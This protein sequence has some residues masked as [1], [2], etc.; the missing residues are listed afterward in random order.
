MDDPRRRVPR[1]D[2]LLADPR[3]AEAERVLGRA[4]VKSVV[5]E[6]QQRARAGEIE[7]E[8]VADARRRRTAASARRACGPSSTPPASSCTPTWAARRCRRPRWTRWSP[9]AAPPTSSSTW[10]PAA[11]PA[12]VAVRW[13][14]WPARCPTAGGVHVVNNN[15][16]ALL[17]TAM[18]LAP[19]KEI[20]VS[21]G[22]LIEIGDGFR[23]PELMAVDRFADPRG[24]HHQ[25]HPPA[26][27]RRRDRAGHRLRAQGAPV[28]LPRHAASPRRCRSPSW[29]QLD[30]P[31]VV[32]IGSGLLTP[33]PLLPDEPDATTVL[34]DGADLVTASGDKLLGGPQAGLL[35][36]D[37]ELIERLRRHPAAR[38]LRVDKLTLAALEATLVGPPPPVAQALDAD[39]TELRARAEA[40]RRAAARGAGGGLHRGRRRRR[41]TRRRA[42]ERRRQ[43]ARVLRR[44][45]AHRHAGGRRAARGRPLPARP[46]HGRAGGRRGC[47]SRRCGHV[48]RSHRRSRRP[49][50]VDARAAAHRHVARPAGRGAAPRPDHRPRLRVDR[51]RRTAV[52]VRRR[53]G[54]RAVRREHARRRRPGARGDVRRRRDRGLD[55]AVRRAP[56][57]AATR[58]ASGTCWS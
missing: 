53:A 18:T 4:L 12:A 54:P 25:P 35:F 31:L 47:W 57:R 15:A 9:P 42:A 44:T 19:G 39:V 1:T 3:L 20:V 56:R 38:A 34:R 22:E 2:V 27:L 30:V 28:E 16:A 14:R 46:A 50:Q 5:A 36:G 26:R 45:A 48:R 13:P 11:A 43:P 33:H 37:A 17:L 40:A 21:R 8:Q 7:P 49:R 55:A 32:D 51:D 10:K 29:R 41:G 6:A 24:R 58:S 23:L 52:R